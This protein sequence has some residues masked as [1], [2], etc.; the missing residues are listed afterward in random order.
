MTVWTAASDGTGWK[1]VEETRLEF[2]DNTGSPQMP[3]VASGHGKVIVITPDRLVGEQTV[4]L[5]G[6]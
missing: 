4:V 6:D 1:P 2:D 3:V 5:V